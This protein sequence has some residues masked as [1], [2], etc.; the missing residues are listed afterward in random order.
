MS[1]S[2]SQPG[3]SWMDGIPINVRGPAPGSWHDLHLY[4]QDPAEPEVKVTFGAKRER[5]TSPQ[6][7]KEVEGPRHPKPHN[8][9][10]RGRH[11]PHYQWERWL[12][13]LGYDTSKQKSHCVTPYKKPRDGTLSDT[14][15]WFNK[16]HMLARSRVERLFSFLD[17]FRIFTFCSHEL[18]FLH[19]AMVLACSTMYLLVGENPQYSDCFAN[20]SD[21]QIRGLGT[22][23]SGS[24]LLLHEHW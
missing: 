15:L 23:E 19:E 9:N 14:Q 18:T 24:H 3:R 20:L 5:S 13:D 16:R 11:F 12:G 8:F 22:A 21:D 17:I 10:L 1:P 6:E 4:R 7:V 2:S